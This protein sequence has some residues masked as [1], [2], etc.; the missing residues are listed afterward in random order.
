MPFVEGLQMHRPNLCLLN[1]TTPQEDAMARTA[2]IGPAIYEQVGKLVAEGKNRTEAF[3]QVAKE[4]KSSP[5]TVA[6]NYYRM[7]RQQGDGRKPAARGRGRRQGSKVKGGIYAAQQ[8]LGRRTSAADGDI[9]HTAS[10]ITRLVQQLVSQ[11]EERDRRM[12][13]LLG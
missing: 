8:D 12:R 10:E 3:A 11:V 1:E 4:R 5:G 6:A 9:R 7:A 2:T 13:E